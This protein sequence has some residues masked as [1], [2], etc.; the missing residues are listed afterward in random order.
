MVPD[1]QIILLK[2][3]DFLR[4]PIMA[5]RHVRSTV[6]IST[7]P[8]ATSGTP[9]G[10]ADRVGTAPVSVNV[11]ADAL[12]PHA[13]MPRTLIVFEPCHTGKSLR[14]RYSFC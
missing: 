10:N 9:N 13:D 7:S 12:Q 4:A 5:R 14:N 2:K 6:D 3:N 1:L 8:P 11:A